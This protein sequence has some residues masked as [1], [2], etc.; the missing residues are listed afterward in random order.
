MKR[1][2]TFIDFLTC[3]NII[4]LLLECLRSYVIKNKELEWVRVKKKILVHKT[5]NKKSCK[6]KDINFKYIKRECSSFQDPLRI[7]DKL[8]YNHRYSKSQSHSN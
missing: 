8:Q 2:Y 7:S 4:C 5:I 6:K 1:I 3:E